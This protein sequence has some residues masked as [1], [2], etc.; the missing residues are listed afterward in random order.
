MQ[1]FGKDSIY[2]RHSEKVIDDDDETHKTVNS[3]LQLIRPML[4][5]QVEVSVKSC[6]EGQKNEILVAVKDMMMNQSPLGLV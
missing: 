5:N 4:M 6:M 2:S 3:F 1:Q